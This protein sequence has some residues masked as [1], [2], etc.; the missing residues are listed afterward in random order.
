MDNSI[1]NSNSNPPDTHYPF[2]DLII[3][4]KLVNILIQKL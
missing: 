2:P 4:D 1:A 3:V